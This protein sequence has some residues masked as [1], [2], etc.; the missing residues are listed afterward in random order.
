MK[1]PNWFRMVWWALLLILISYFLFQ[2]YPDL[3]QGHAIATDF[4]IFLIWAVLVLVPFVQEIDFF[5]MELKQAIQEL[6]SELKSQVLSLRSEIRSTQE[7]LNEANLVPLPDA[8]LPGLEKRAQIAIKKAIQEHG[9][10][11]EG[12]LNQQPSVDDYTQLLFEARYGIERELR[13]I[14][15]GRLD[16]AAGRNP[17]PITEVIQTLN[18]CQLL[19]SSLATVIRE[20]YAICSSAIHGQTPSE[21]QVHFVQNLLPG[22]LKALRS[23]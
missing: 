10:P 5:G 9:S 23:V 14:G 4:F 6:R 21:V 20:V 18:G 13:R 12:T 11:H 8:E 3:S 16:I 2:R 7:I 17:C 1:L 15:A 19:D 22:L